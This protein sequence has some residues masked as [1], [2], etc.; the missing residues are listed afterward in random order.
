MVVFFADTVKQGE[1]YIVL[2]NKRSEEMQIYE[3]SSRNSV[4]SVD[5]Y[6]EIALILADPEKAED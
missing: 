1:E 5:E 2:L 6:E 4:R 3:L